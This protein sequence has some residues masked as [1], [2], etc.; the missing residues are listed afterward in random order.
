[1]SRSLDGYPARYLTKQLPY[2]VH[3]PLPVSGW[4][5]VSSPLR[6][7]VMF[8]SLFHGYLVVEYRRDLPAAGLARL[9][10]WVGSHSRARVV[11][12][13]ARGVDAPMVDAA[14]WGWELRCAGTAPTEVALDRL[15]ARRGA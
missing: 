8:H 14:E 1:M 6:F 11:A 5:G 13:P 3:P 10:S 4:R 2:R 12:T 15:A 7:E 9:R